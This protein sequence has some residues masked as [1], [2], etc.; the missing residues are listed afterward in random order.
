MNIVIRE[1]ETSTRT[2]GQE[3]RTRVLFFSHC[4][5]PCICPLHPYPVSCTL[6]FRMKKTLLYIQSF[7]YIAAG[8]NHFRVPFSYRGILPP[9]IPAPGAAVTV[10]GI[11]EIVL[12]AALLSR[13]ARKTAAYGIVLMLLAF[14]PVHIYFVQENSC[15]AALCFPGWV[16]WV[17]LL[18][19]H[20][21]L[22]AWAWWYRK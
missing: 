12:G 3:A 11:A 13:P 22:L 9:Y 20:P 5:V 21:I 18:V 2:K 4:L 6:L 15:L 16:G 17:R 14:L 7:F 10:S 1:Q 8:C 19:I